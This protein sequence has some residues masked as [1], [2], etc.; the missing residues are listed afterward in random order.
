MTPDGRCHSWRPGPRPHTPRHEPGRCRS[1]W[2]PCWAR[3]P[4]DGVTVR[5][6]ACIEAIL[7]LNVPRFTRM[8]LEEAYV[9]ERLNERLVSDLDA[10]VALAASER[11]G[12]ADSVFPEVLS[13][14]AELEPLGRRTTSA[15]P[16]AELEAAT[17]AAASAHDG[18]EP[19][20]AA[21]VPAG[22]TGDDLDDEWGD[23]QW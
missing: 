12:H 21:P 22:R 5:C 15:H 18:P 1:C 11:L 16:T 20:P 14:T 4:R 17:R 2:R 23:E 9:P 3:V 6:E 7:A 13:P 8:L 19:E 10:G